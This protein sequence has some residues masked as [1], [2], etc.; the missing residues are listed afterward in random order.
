MLP[1]R[2]AVDATALISAAIKGRALH[3][4]LSAPI[5]EFLTT[6][7][8][9]EE[10]RSYLPTLCEK[11]KRVPLIDSELIL[12]TLP[13]VIL[14]KERYHQKLIE[15]HTLIGRKDK[16]DTDLLALALQ[17]NVP[18]WSE[19]SDFKINEVKRIIKTFTTAELFRIWES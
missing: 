6:S 8:T 15:A 5:K 9:F 3:I 18:I 12:N 10:A 13:L 19:D 2:I 7:F 16:K 1:E 4:F 17:E 11:I 14:E